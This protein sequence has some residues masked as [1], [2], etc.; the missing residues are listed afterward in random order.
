MTP[1]AVFFDVDFTLIHPGPTFR[2]EG[3]EAFGVRYGLTVDRRHF[4]AAVNSAASLLD[5][6]SLSVYDAEVYVAYTRHILEGMGGSGDALDPC[7][8]EIFA[9]WA[10]NHHFDLYDDVADVLS[11]LDA[12]GFRIGLISNSHRCLSSFQEHFE[13][14]SMIDGAVSSAEHGWMKPHASIFEA[15]MQTIGVSAAE[16][17]MVGDSITHDVEGALDA[18]MRAIFLHRAEPRHP[19]ETELLSRGVPTISSL[20]QLP[21]VLATFGV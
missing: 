19:R 9:E 11:V 16:S 14:R 12:R 10:G 15:A 13:L 18:G 17:V 5:D 4:G 6:H 1:R 8:R 7:A 2:A 21:Q 3:Y 20:R